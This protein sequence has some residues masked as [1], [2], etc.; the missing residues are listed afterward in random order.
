MLIGSMLA[1]G[2]AKEVGV[3]FNTMVSQGF[4]QE[5]GQL[6]QHMVSNNQVFDAAMAVANMNVGAATQLVATLPVSVEII[7][8]RSNSFAGKCLSSGANNGP[9]S[10]STI[11]TD[12]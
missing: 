11:G 7:I 5:L 6:V 10:H 3:L 8:N 4:T 12:I 2:N 1:Q 9:A